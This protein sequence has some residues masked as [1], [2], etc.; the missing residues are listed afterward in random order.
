[1]NEL[2]KTTQNND[3]DVIVSGRELH[4]FLEVATEYKKWFSRMTAYG[5]D[6]NTDFVRVTQKSPT[7]GGLQNIT[8]HH[9]KLDMAKEISMIQRTSRGKQARQYFLKIEKFW[10]SPEMIMKRA[11][12]FADKRIIELETT[13][14]DQKPKVFLAEAIQISK[15]AILVK[16]L[17]TLL[18]QKGV[19]IGQNRLF[20]WMREN[21]YLCSKGSYYNK[22]TQRAMDMELFEVKTHIH[23]SD[24]GDTKTK[25]TPK[26]TGKGQSYFINKLLKEWGVLV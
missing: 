5:F 17:A 3:G 8:D 14:E 21:G 25:Y 10:N 7:L 4:E 24:N 22:P 16:E 15:N 2:I 1:M 11:L 9:L 20:A 18:K 19:D 12:E 6:E 13:I 26:V 23:T